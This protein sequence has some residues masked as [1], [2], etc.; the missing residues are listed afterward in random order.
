MPYPRST[1]ILALAAMGFSAPAAALRPS[2]GSLYLHARAAEV[3]GDVRGAA[4]G[5]ATLLAEAPGDPVIANRAYRQALSGGDMDLAI[6]AARALQAQQAIPS[7][8]RLL[9]AL[10][11]IKSRNWAEANEQTEKLGQDRVFGFV[12]PYLRAWIAGG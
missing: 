11:A 2:L 1:L 4:A 10:T 3:A 9:L 12:V 7:D 6:R 5:F 8:G